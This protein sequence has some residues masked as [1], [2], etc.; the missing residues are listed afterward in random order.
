MIGQQYRSVRWPCLEVPPLPLFSF[1][2]IDWPKKYSTQQSN[3]TIYKYAAEYSMNLISCIT[4]NTHVNSVQLITVMFIT[5][6]CQIK[7][8]NLELDRLKT[9]FNTVLIVRK[10][11]KPATAWIFKCLM[12][13][14]F[15]SEC[16][17]ISTLCAQCVLAL[18]Y[19]NMIRWL[20]GSGL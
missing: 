2:C 16:K 11:T 7:C 4:T 13:S 17:I 3:A 5:R 18:W 19:N 20:V 15:I 12:L 14:W 9:S 6:R 10:T 8:G 1:L